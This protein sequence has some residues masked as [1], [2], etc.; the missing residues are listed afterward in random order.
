MSHV[1]QDGEITAVTQLLLWVKQ[2]KILNCC[3]Y[4][5][6]TIIRHTIVLDQDNIT[7]H[8]KMAKS[9]LFNMLWIK[10]IKISI[11]SYVLANFVLSNSI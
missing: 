10:Q 6:R 4:F 11:N 2:N 9:S 3:K 5:V 7:P 1:D 8:V